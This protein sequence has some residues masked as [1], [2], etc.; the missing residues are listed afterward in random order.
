MNTLFLISAP[1][2]SGKTSIM[3]QVMD[4]EVI[5]FTTREPRKGEVNGID[6][7]YISQKEFDQM[8]CDGELAEYITYG[9]TGD[10][11]G[12]TINELEDKL[13]NGD[14]FAIVTE[15]GMEQL[16]IIYPKC[17]T[18]FIYTDKEDATEFMRLR[19]DKEETIQKRLSTFDKEQYNK[20]KYDYIIRNKKGEMQDAVNII[21]EIVRIV[22][23]NNRDIEQFKK[24]YNCEWIGDKNG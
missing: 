3:R 5:S 7:V 13:N 16:K 10:S 4:N 18:I 17:S 19:G 11:Y 8:L 24:E 20:D 15:H 6:Y 22:G 12:I 1:S 2:G 21:K 9:A 14:A 23:S